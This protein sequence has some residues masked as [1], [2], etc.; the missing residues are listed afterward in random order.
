MRVASGERL[1]AT[2][3]LPFAASERGKQ[4]GRKA[5]RR[6][7]SQ[8]EL[9]FRAT[10]K[11]LSPQHRNADVGKPQVESGAVHASAV[12]GGGGG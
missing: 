1:A 5:G 3:W 7:S 10:I 11:S 12:L 8:R 2:G 4:A 6:Q 9:T